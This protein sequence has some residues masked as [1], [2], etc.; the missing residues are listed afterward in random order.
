MSDPIRK[1]SEWR[2]SS[3][4]HSGGQLAGAVGDAAAIGQLA[5]ERGYF[6]KS[7][8]TRAGGEREAGV[9]PDDLGARIVAE[10]VQ[11]RRLV[12]MAMQIEIA[13]DREV[14]DCLTSAPAAALPEMWNSPM[15]R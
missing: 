14:D 10:Q 11:Q 5:P 7:S 4:R 2:V 13:L 12:A 1:R 9:R 3:S 6:S 15:P 8:S